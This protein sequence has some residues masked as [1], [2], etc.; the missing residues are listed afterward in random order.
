MRM[1][2]IVIILFIVYLSVGIF[3]QVFDKD[4]NAYGNGGTSFFFNT[5]LQPWQWQGV[6]NNFFYF[7]G[8]ILVG[9]IGVAVAGSLFGRSDISSLAITAG[10]FASIGV[11]PCVSLYSFITRNVGLFACPI[12]ELC[13]PAQ[14]AGAL[15][16]GILAMIYLFTV[17][18][19][20]FWRA[21]TQ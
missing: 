20:W 1:L 16:A 14:I 4:L 21:M 15:T 7:F 5:L 18:E 10:V 11:I 2:N 17:M 9:A 3:D 19:W 6:S 12:G 13:G 8:A